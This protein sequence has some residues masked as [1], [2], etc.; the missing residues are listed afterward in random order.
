MYD[1]N[2]ITMDEIREYLTQK[3]GDH[4]MEQHPEKDEDFFKE[5]TTSWGETD[6]DEMFNF[7]KKESEDDDDF[8]SYF[9][10]KGEF[11]MSPLK[12]MDMAESFLG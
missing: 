5:R 12:F 3:Y 10:M 2:T 4:P 6:S 7:A 8:N 11:T 9:N 1:P